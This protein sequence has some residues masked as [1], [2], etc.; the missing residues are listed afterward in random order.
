AG[1]KGL[2]CN[3]S[4]N[5]I[6]TGLYKSLDPFFFV[7]QIFIGLI[8]ENGIA[9]SVHYF[10]D[11]CHDRTEEI[12]LEARNNDSYYICSSR[13]QRGSQLILLVPQLFGRFENL[14]FSTDTYS[15]MIV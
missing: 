13:P 7:D 12:D 9:I 15:R 1:D 5:T 8:K 2:L 14:F 4:N 6:Y 11:T 10:F 3:G